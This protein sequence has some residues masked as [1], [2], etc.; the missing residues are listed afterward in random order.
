MM[1]MSE[2]TL[3][4]L[5][6]SH[7]LQDPTWCEYCK[8]RVIEGNWE[9][10]LQSSTHR[11]RARFRCK[12]YVLQRYREFLQGEGE[13]TEYLAPTHHPT[14]DLVTQVSFR[15]LSG[16]VFAEWDVVV[17][18][19][20]LMACQLDMADFLQ[21]HTHIFSIQYSGVP[22]RFIGQEAYLARRLY[23][24]RLRPDGCDLC[25][26]WHELMAF[27]QC[28]KLYVCG[29]CLKCPNWEYE[30][31]CWGCMEPNNNLTPTQA[32]RNLVLRRPPVAQQE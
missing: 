15:L 14:M 21:V 20:G 6:R 23:P 9:S 16:T 8:R 5:E 31:R 10:H 26:C 1:A 22:P 12:D 11:W 18:S 25:F 30:K 27:C 4:N 17:T 28:C 19:V 24:L 32:A 7:C 2:L 3:R 29:V 13:L